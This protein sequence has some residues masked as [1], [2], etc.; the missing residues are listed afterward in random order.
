[1]T[2][3][4][5]PVDAIGAD[6][7]F[8]IGGGDF[9]YGQGVTEGYVNSLYNSPD[10][11]AENLRDPLR[12]AL[13]K[14]PITQLDMFKPM[15]PGYGTPTSKSDAVEKIIAALIPNT[16][17]MTPEEFQ[18]WLTDIF[19]PNSAIW[20]KSQQD[21]TDFLAS[22]GIG[23]SDA[24][25]AVIAKNKKDWDDFLT[26]LG[27][28]YNAEDAAAA[29][30]KSKADW[31]AFLAT[32][33]IGDSEAAAAVV[34]KSKKDWEDFLTGL[35][36]GYDPVTAAAAVAKSKKDWEDFLA[37]LGIGDSE[38]AAAIVAKS[39]A[40]WDA[41]LASLGIGDSEAAAAVIAKNKADWDAFLTG[42]GIGDSEAAAAV[43]AKSKSDWDAFLTNLGISTST[44]AATKVANSQAWL[45][46]F[47][48]AWT[49]IS[50]GFHLTYQTGSVGDAPGRIWT[51]AGFG[52]G[53]MTWYGAWNKMLQLTGLVNTTTAPSDAAPQ[54]ANRIVGAE[55]AH[56][57]LSDAVTSGATGVST[58]GADNTKA[59]ESVASLKAT[60]DDSIK[61]VQQINNRLDDVP[62]G[63]VVSGVPVNTTASTG[64]DAWG[65]DWS[66]YP[67]VV[68]TAGHAELGKGWFLNNTG[69]NGAKGL[70]VYKTP[71]T[72]PGGASPTD[73]VCNVS[74]QNVPGFWSSDTNGSGF[75]IAGASGT[76]LGSATYI[77]GRFS[78]NQFQIG[79]ATGGTM[80]VLATKAVSNTPAS[81]AMSLVVRPGTVAD[82]WNIGLTAGGVSVTS[83]N[84][85][86]SF[87]PGKYFG[88]G[89]MQGSDP[90]PPYVSNFTAF[91]IDTSKIPGVGS[92]F[93]ST[94]TLSFN[95]TV[96][97]VPG[98]DINTADTDFNSVDVSSIS[99]AGIQVVRA[100]I[101]KVQ[102]IMP[103]T[104]APD[105]DTVVSGRYYINGTAIA[106]YSE[107]SG[108]YTFSTRRT[109]YQFDF[110]IPVHAGDVISFGWS[111][112]KNLASGKAICFI[113]RMGALK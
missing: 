72:A 76:A 86:L 15:V 66:F 81:L 5:N 90:N 111:Q 84:T 82:K 23:D 88:H 18:Q 105:Q 19:D 26:G 55:T 63:T 46:D 42:L 79:Y 92:R 91:N 52:Y 38:A 68:S 35:G 77:Y 48:N 93:L 37:G 83:N 95:T 57:G 58:T 13:T 12:T 65:T 20:L 101:Y 98:W 10:L 33:G 54:I 89:I 11:S 39:K 87:T 24:A 99:N 69:G 59:M 41:F 112:N 85:T 100:G 73:S 56:Q 3:P 103:Y 25:A 80:T 9:D 78:K 110:M 94:T 70:G 30:A 104:T 28:G 67:T 1:M 49:V 36:I 6:G 7:A 74:F 106:D 32:L 34:A 51:T 61:S 96:N 53:K 40:D 75:L 109:K 50:D 44:Q 107:Q 64:V 43:V 113:A 8:E 62:Q 102:I 71:V 47:I 97:G 22:L 27:I 2:Y 45:K 29:V 108:S 60:L 21:W 16:I 14:L 31:E 17:P 4:S